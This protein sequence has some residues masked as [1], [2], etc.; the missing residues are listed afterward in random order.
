MLQQKDGSSVAYQPG[1]D[2]RGNAVT[3]ADV[4][5]EAG[6]PVGIAIPESI[7]IDIGID[8]ADRLGRRDQSAAR[9]LLPVEGRARLGVLTIKGSDAFW[10]G[11]KIAPRD[12]MALAESCR[13]AL[14]GGDE[15]RPLPKP[16]ER[17]N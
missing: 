13:V 14:G 17:R 11:E 9:A 7:D 2:V 3:P 6:G 1:V 4:G 16:P 12:Q 10:N 8:L 15:V 5:T